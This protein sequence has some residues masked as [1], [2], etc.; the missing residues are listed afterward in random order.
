MESVGGSL[1][2][3]PAPA[4]RVDAQNR[5][6]DANDLALG[7]LGD[8][9]ANGRALADFVTDPARLALFLQ[10]VRAGEASAVR[11]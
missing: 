1:H 9:N 2:G 6:H 5:V 10:S 11:L 3:I 7:L 4:I 8:R